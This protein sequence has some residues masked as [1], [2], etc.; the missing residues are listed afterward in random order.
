MRRF[1]AAEVAPA[2]LRRWSK[3][4][5]ARKKHAS[6]QEPALLRQYRKKPFPPR[7]RRK[8][9]QSWNSFGNPSPEIIEGKG[10]PERK[11]STP[12]NP[13]RSPLR[14]GSKPRSKGDLQSG[15]TTP[16]GQKTFLPCPGQL[17]ADI[18]LPDSEI[19]I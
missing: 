7:G 12:S 6:I 16:A 14:V 3:R 2:V 17:D 13:G 11:T 15:R 8:I 10:H 18:P 9:G 4:S 1:A 5:R 19:P